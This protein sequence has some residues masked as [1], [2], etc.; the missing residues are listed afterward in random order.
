MSF[1]FKS[2]RHSGEEG[3]WPAT[4]VVRISAVPFIPD[5]F[6]I[7]I[8]I[9]FRGRDILGE[10]RAVAKHWTLPP[11]PTIS[12]QCSR[13]W[14]IQVAAVSM[15]TIR[16]FQIWMNRGRPPDEFCARCQICRLGPIEENLYRNHEVGFVNVSVFTRRD[17]IPYST[18][19]VQ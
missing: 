14:Q 11:R 17:K 8:I 3:P 19:A 7:E 2:C 9:A 16:R 15:D 13:F 6:S 1:R 4:P 10:H 5:Y 18:R 12:V